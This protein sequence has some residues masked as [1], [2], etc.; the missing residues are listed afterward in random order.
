MVASVFFD[1]SLQGCSWCKESCSTSSD[2]FG[3]W[4]YCSNDV[5]GYCG[6]IQKSKNDAI[7][8]HNNMCRA[9]LI[10]DEIAERIEFFIKLRKKK[11]SKYQNPSSKDAQIGE[12]KHLIF[13]LDG[14]KHYI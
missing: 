11:L 3:Y 14:G 6:P 9:L 2:Q 1:D 10:R 13:L 7:E 5:C 4:V 12:L 8:T